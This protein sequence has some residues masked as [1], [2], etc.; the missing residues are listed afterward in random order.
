MTYIKFNTSQINFRNFHQD[1]YREDDQVAGG[2][3]KLG[4][5]IDMLKTSPAQKHNSGTILYVLEFL[6]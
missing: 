5:D 6:S 4:R 1:I 2:L 3:A